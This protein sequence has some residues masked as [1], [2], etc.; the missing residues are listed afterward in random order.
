MCITVFSEEILDLDFL[1]TGNELLSHWDT[2]TSNHL[3]NV[4][5]ILHLLVRPVLPETTNEHR[6]VSVFTL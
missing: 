2:P 6:G 5:R 3:N 1:E 4:T